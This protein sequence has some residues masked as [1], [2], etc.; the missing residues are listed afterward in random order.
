MN[1]EV[2]K[3]EEKAIRWTPETYNIPQP[4]VIQPL[5]LVKTV[6]VKSESG[7][8]QVQK[9]LEP[10][11]YTLSLAITDKVSGKSVTKTIDFEIK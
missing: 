4:L 7:E 5:P 10:G 3:G 8:K 2:L 9:P 6:L 11:K 1:Y